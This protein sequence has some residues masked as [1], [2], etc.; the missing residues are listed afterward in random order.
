MPHFSENGND[1]VICQLC[2][3]P[4]DTGA[5]KV[6]WRPDLTRNKSA[7]NVCARCIQKEESSPCPVCNGLGEIAVGMKKWQRCERCNGVG[8][9]PLTQEEE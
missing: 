5:E 3:R 9:L 6:A 8:N 2:A 7:G 4:I 1:V